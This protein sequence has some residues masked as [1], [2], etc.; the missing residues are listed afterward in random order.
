MSFGDGIEYYFFFVSY[1]VMLDLYVFDS[2]MKLG[3]LVVVYGRH[4]AMK[5]DRAFSMRDYLYASYQIS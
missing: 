1:E 5:N 3:V 2:S 4:V